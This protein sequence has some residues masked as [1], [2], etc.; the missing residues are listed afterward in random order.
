M[1]RIHLLIAI[2][3]ITAC[4]NTEEGSTT[5]AESEMVSSLNVQDLLA[6]NSKVNIGPLE[7]RTIQ[8]PVNCSGRIEIPPNE[9]ISVHAKTDGF[10]EAIDYL[11]G[12]FV[13]KGSRLFSVSNPELIEKQ[14]L[15]SETKAELDQV[16]REYERQRTLNEAQASSLKQFEE[17]G[18]R[19]QLLHARYEGL[20]S[21]LQLIGVNVNSLIDSQ[22]YQSRIGIYARESGYVHEV[23]VNK[24][25]MVHPEDVLMEMADDDHIHL[26]LQV[27]S[28][29]ASMIAIDQ[30]VNFR[31]PQDPMVYHAKVVK[32]NHMLDARTGSLKVHCHISEEHSTHIKVGMNVQAQI[33][34]APTELVGLPLYAVVKEGENY[35]GYVVQNGMLEKRAL[36]NVRVQGD[37][38]SFDTD[39]NAEWVIKGAYYIK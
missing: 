14:R 38:I 22:N 3:L 5:E 23:M 18:S 29:D 17:V 10:I 6:S 7:K 25:Q 16:D 15:F 20:K 34:T 36:E 21:E 26:E 32:V 19:R 31:I 11:P 8:S 28:K 12:D 9:F 2:L 30:K 1:N 13:K 24:G 4:Q 39:P 33:E 37:F 35:Y 27:L